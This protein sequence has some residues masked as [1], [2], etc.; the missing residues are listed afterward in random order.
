MLACACPTVDDGVVRV[1]LL[2]LSI[3]T[4]GA[5]VLP[6]LSGVTL[7]LLLPAGLVVAPLLVLPLLLVSVLLLPDFFSTVSV[8]GISLVVPS[9]NVTVTSPLSFT[10]TLVAVGLA[11]ETASLTLAFSASVKCAGS[12]TGVTSTL[13][14][15][16]VS[17]DGISLVVPS[18][19]VTVT[20]PLSFTTTLVAVGLAFETASLTLA[21]SASVKCAGSA[22]GVTS[23]LDFSTVSVDGI[24]LVVPSGNVTVTSPLSFTTT[25]VAV[26]LAFETA[27]LTLAFSASVKCAGS[28]TGVTSTL[29]FSTVSVDGISLVVPSGNVTVT[30]P[31]SFTTT[32][33]AVGLAFETASLT[34]AFSASVKCAGS[35][36]GVTSTLD[37]S[38]VSVD[39]IS[40][41]VPSGNVTV[42]SPLSFTTT[43]V[44]VGLAFE[45]ASLTLA[46][47]ASVKCAGSA[48]G[49]TSTLDFS[50]VSVD[51]ISLVVPSGNVTVT[52]PL[53]FTTTLVAVGL[54]FETASLTLAFSASVKCAGSATGVTSTLDFSTVSVDG[55]S[56]V[57]PS[58]NVTVT[59]PLSFTTTLVA[60]GL[61]FETASLTLAF[62]ASVKCAGSATGV[63]STLDFSTVSVDG[64]SLV[65]PSG[66]V[67]V[68]SPLSFTT[69]LVA[70]GLAF[71]TASLTLAFSASVKC[72]GSA[73]GVTSTLDF[74]TVSV[75]GISLVVPSGNVT[76]TSP[77]SFT[78]TLVAV[79]LAFETAS[80]TLAFSASVKCAGSATGVTSTL[81]F[82]TVSVDGISLVV[83]SGNVT[84]TSPLSFTTTLVAVGLAFETASLTLAFSASVKCAGSATGVT[85]TLDF[86][87]VSVD[88]ISLV[89]PSGNVTVTSPL[90]FTTTLVAVGLAFET[91]SLTLAFSASVKC[92]SG[93][94]FR[95]LYGFCR[96]N[97]FSCSIW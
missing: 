54:A 17:V 68:T 26:G 52:S 74:S 21:F 94:N 59:S 96:W 71:E 42:T 31:L 63:T 67:T 72:A 30:S 51:G 6:L 65:V 81:D 24:S 18:G 88:G 84:V 3:V 2:L 44:A 25:L 5:G 70:V 40:L 97:F 8:D 87:T 49:V 33:V 36:T 38:T 77:L 83:P 90:S 80:L 89:V 32:L 9:G 82:S 92:A 4:P 11:F 69:T 1:V 20:S 58:G 23:T 37:F 73:T 35:A 16:T 29:D 57:V 75:D 79:G 64:I 13:D 66:N 45:T 7:L 46:F 53:S 22:T 60:V 62:S 50:T 91:A 28:A 12:A 76:V 10:T 86:S 95:F 93:V 15:S 85:S 19:N 34:L 61:A 41:V 27:S 55:I 39:G 47:S 56:L 78:T 48:T 14:F 43:L